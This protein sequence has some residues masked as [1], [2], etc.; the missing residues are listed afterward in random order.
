MPIHTWNSD[1]EQWMRRCVELTQE[2]G[3]DLPIRATVVLCGGI[4][5]EHSNETVR[6]HE[7]HRHA[8]LL[9]LLEAEKTLSAEELQR[10][11]LYSLIEPCAM[12]S[13][14]VRKLNVGR[15]VFGLRSPMMGGYSRWNILQDEGLVAAFSLKNGS[16]PEVVPDV[17][18]SLVIDKWKRWNNAKWERLSARGLFT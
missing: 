17:M 18:K 9:A 4:V 1:D 2:S 13:F 7:F 12:C 11:T 8:E 14:A 15:V 6:T 10:C 16:I 3:P 5:S